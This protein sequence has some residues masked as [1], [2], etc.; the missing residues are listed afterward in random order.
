MKRVK[1]LQDLDLLVAV[2]EISCCF[3]KLNYGLIISHQNRIGED[4][5]PA[6]QTGI[7]IRETQI[8]GSWLNPSSTIMKT[9]ISVGVYINPN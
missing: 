8:M 6:T 4:G 2:R 3:V 1:S 7:E 5:C 9:F